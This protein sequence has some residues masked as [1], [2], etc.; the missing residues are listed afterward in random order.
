MSKLNPNCPRC[1]GI[2]WYE[3]P[4]YS[5]LLPSIEMHPC[6]DCHD[7][8]TPTKVEVTLL[9]MGFALIFLFLLFSYGVQR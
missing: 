3:G 7:L 6:P 2:G 5:S 1:K 4:D 8:R 9:A